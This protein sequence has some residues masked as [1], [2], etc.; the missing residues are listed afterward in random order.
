MAPRLLQI[1]ETYRRLRAAT[2]RPQPLLKPASFLSA[3]EAAAMAEFGCEHATLPENILLELSALDAQANPPPGG[4]GAAA[5][6]GP[7]PRLAHL[8]AVDPLAGPEWDGRLAATD[9]D[10]L[11]D[12][13]AALEKAIAADPITVKG[14]QAALEFFQGQE[15]QM[16]AAVEEILKQV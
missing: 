12:N 13:G 14:I 11:A 10:Y 4:G 5:D 6:G 7:S 9:V 16:R 2:G 8:L 3:R 1:A 15:M